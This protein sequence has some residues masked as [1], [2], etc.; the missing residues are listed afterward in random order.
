MCTTSAVSEETV[1]LPP[2][3]KFVGWRSLSHLVACGDLKWTVME[4]LRRHPESLDFAFW[5][6]ES[7]KRRLLTAVQSIICELNSQYISVHGIYCTHSRVLHLRSNQRYSI[8]RPQ[9]SEPDASPAHNPQTGNSIIHL[10][11][12]TSHGNPSQTVL[13]DR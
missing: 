11:V 8:K 4:K 7:L 9:R 6:L 13:G 1:A 5:S 12:S 2:A 10:T 3:G